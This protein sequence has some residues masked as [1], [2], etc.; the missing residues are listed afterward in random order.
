M[1]RHPRSVELLLQPHSDTGCVSC[2]QTGAATLTQQDRQLDPG[3][4]SLQVALQGRRC[5][6]EVREA[7]LVLFTRTFAMCI[8]R[9]CVHNLF[10][11]FV[12][13]GW[14]CGDSE[15]VATA[16]ECTQRNHPCITRTYNSHLKVF[17]A[18]WTMMSHWNNGSHASRAPVLMS[19]SGAKNALK[20]W[21]MVLLRA[22]LTTI[23]LLLPVVFGI[24]NCSAVLADELHREKSSHCRCRT[25]FSSCSPGVASV[26][27]SPKVWNDVFPSE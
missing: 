20:T 15:K 18:F 2:G 3:Q 8:P 13:V 14:V 22:T 27:S 17:L 25:S 23:I 24:V 9:S 1:Q 12:W 26:L 6:L 5:R 16:D 11:L 21:V 7:L 19:I 10:L 4:C